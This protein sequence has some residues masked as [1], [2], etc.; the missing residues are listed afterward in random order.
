MTTRIRILM[1]LLCVAGAVL[2]FLSLNPRSP[3]DPFASPRRERLHWLEDEAKLRNAIDEFS[4]RADDPWGLYGEP[5]RQ[6]AEAELAYL[7]EHYP[8]AFK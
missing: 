1:C 4:L 3:F 6:S 8:E 7:R 5:T 2:S